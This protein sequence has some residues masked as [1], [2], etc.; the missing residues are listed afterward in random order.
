LTF[1][2]NARSIALNLLTSQSKASVTKTSAAAA[3]L[4][5]LPA[6]AWL[7]LGLGNLG[8]DVAR[9][10]REFSGAGGQGI[11][12]ALDGRLL[13]ELNSQLHGLR[14]ERDI[15]PWLGNAAL[16]VSGSTAKTIGGALVVHSTNPAA[17][18]AAV[19]R[20]LA[21]LRGIRGLTVRR[22]SIAGA[23]AALTV[24]VK[25]L[26]SPLFVLDGHGI[27][28]VALG[29]SAARQALAPQGA[30]GS[31][32]EYRAA[33]AALGGGLKPTFLLSIPTLAGLILPELPASTAAQVRPYLRAF[34]VLAVASTHTGSSDTARIAIGLR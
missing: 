21:A 14:I 32:G 6:G 23:D 18:K 5:S 7:G 30:L 2:A 1:S 28:A 15:L 22:A 34:T 19:S 16:F 3:T 31:S 10:L 33:S 29:A 24:H 17:S 20:I 13:S 11:G 8:A 25:A 4:A 27:F 9:A 12:S 26:R